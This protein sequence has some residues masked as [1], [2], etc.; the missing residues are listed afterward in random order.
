MELVPK[1]FFSA[2]KPFAFLTRCAPALPSLLTAEP[3]HP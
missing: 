3:D 2:L 1:P